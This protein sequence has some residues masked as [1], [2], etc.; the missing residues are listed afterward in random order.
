MEVLL[1]YS[2]EIDFDIIDTLIKRLKRTPAFQAIGTTKRKR[3]YCVFVEC[4]DNLYKHKIND[5]PSFNGKEFQP[6][7]ILTS[8][9]NK[10]AIGTGNVISNENIRELSD[11]LRQINQSDR[12]GLKVMYAEIIN[13]DIISN[14]EGAGLGLITMALK[15]EEKIE[16]KFKK[17]NDL[18]S[19][20]EMKISI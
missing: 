15:T 6:Y 17:I 1:E 20:F 16:Y 11:N 10:Y 13:K 4:V 14:E 12:N 18:C 7:I 5:Q 8:E 2:G 19:F 3:V 9:E